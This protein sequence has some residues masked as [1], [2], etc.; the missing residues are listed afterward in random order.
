MPSQIRNSS[1]ITAT[2]KL[3]DVL[4]GGELENFVRSRRAD[5]R[6]WRLIER[7][8]YEATSG[9]VDVTFETLRTWFPDPPKVDAS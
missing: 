5:A 6:A 8:L 3:A 9:Q 2:R 4:L 7:D 1:R